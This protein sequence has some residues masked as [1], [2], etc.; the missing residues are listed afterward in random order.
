MGSASIHFGNLSLAWH[1][2]W[3]KLAP[4]REPGCIHTRGMWRRLRCN[5]PTVVLLGFRYCLGKCLE[6][7]LRESILRTR[8]TLKPGNARHRIPLGLQL[9]SRQQITQ[10]QLS[11]ALDAQRN[12]GRGKIGEWLLTM[13]FATQ[14]QIT[15]AL[16]RQWRCPVLRNDWPLPSPNRIPSLP[17]AL[18]QSARMIPVGYSRTNSSLYMA[19][20]EGIDY[21]TLYAI[22]QMTAC[23]TD[24]CLAS[25]DLI[26]AGID[27]FSSDSFGNEVVFE[28]GTDVQ[29]FTRIV[30][31]Y[32]VRLNASEIRISVAGSYTWVRL[33]GSGPTLDLMFRSFPTSTEH[34]PSAV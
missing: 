16:A 23:H 3:H 26:Q 32:C 25:P 6:P 34:W 31:S 12:S 11:S 4:N 9:M 5:P 18:M 28:C 8:S 29:E 2:L 22:E 10:E 7:A 17:L 14:Q 15:A 24:P 33:V 13:G 21:N 19:F 27:S 30:R 20:S 1:G